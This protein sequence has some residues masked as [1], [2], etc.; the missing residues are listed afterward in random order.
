VLVTRLP[1][2]GRSITNESQQGDYDLF[3]S[4]MRNDSGSGGRCKTEMKTVHSITITRDNLILLES[5]EDTNQT[6]VVILEKEICKSPYQ[7]KIT[8]HFCGLK[9]TKRRATKLVVFI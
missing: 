7:M 4:S 9:D 6:V 5:S 8:K 1:F 2:G 3:W